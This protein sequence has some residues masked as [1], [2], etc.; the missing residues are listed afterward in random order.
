MHSVSYSFGNFLGV[1][2][3]YIIIEIVEN[4]ELILLDSSFKVSM[5]IVSD[6]T[7]SLAFSFLGL[8]FVSQASVPFLTLS[9]FRLF[10]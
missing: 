9:L 1:V 8:A 10:L 4:Y 7:K 3:L 5:S 2:D 6:L